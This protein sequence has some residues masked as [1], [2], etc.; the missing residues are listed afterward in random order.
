VPSPQ[1]ILPLAVP[2]GIDVTWVARLDAE[3]GRAL[4]AEVH[5]YLGLEPLDPVLIRPEASGDLDA[6]VWE[7]PRHSSSGDDVEAPLPLR[8]VDADLFGLYCWIAGESWMVKALRRCLVAELGV[9]RGQVAFMGYWR[10]GVSMR[11]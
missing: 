6:G 8:A 10:E 1:D 4:V 11:S 5:R 7:T 2:E 9:D 3:H